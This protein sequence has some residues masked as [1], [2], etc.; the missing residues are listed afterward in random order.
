MFVLTLRKHK[1]K[2]IMLEIVVYWTNKQTN[3]KIYPNYTTTKK[4]SILPGEIQYDCLPTPVF[5]LEVAN[6]ASTYQI[7]LTSVT[8]L[9]NQMVN[10]CVW[11]T[12]SKLLINHRTNTCYRVCPQV[13]IPKNYPENQ[14]QQERWHPFMIPC[15]DDKENNVREITPDNE[16]ILL[17]LTCSSS[18][19]EAKKLQI[20]CPDLL[21]AWS[22]EWLTL[23]SAAWTWSL[24]PTIFLFHS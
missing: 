6:F 5:L 18:S 24:C 9:K 23:V 19:S 14:S 20:Y 16:K 1:T 22:T 17:H 11:F 7:L 8:R 12:T 13:N 2:Y 3:S 4:D 21:H 15:L 10:R